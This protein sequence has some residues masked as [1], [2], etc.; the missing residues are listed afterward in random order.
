VNDRL[1]AL[2]GASPCGQSRPKIQRIN[3]SASEKNSGPPKLPDFSAS[4]IS[5]LFRANGAQH[6]DAGGD[7]GPDQKAGNSQAIDHRAGGFAAGGPN[8]W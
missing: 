3:A 4:N 7:F 6:P 5:R 8:V 1:R 2:S